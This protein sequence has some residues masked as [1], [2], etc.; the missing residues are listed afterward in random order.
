MPPSARQLFLGSS[1]ASVTVFASTT[2][3]GIPPIAGQ[4][5]NVMFFRKTLTQTMAIADT[6][7]RFLLM[8]RPMTP[9]AGG[10]FVNQYTVIMD[11]LFTNLPAAGK[12]F[13]L[14]GTIMATLGESFSSNSSGAVGCSGGAG[15]TLTTNAWHRIAIAVDAANTSSGLEIFN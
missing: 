15:G 9:N 13:T 4:P 7:T 10:Y 11:V 14:F 3:F 2:S 1:D 12:T 5:T 6:I 8:P